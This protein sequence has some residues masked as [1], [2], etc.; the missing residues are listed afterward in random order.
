MDPGHLFRDDRNALGE[1]VVL[2][3][4]GP[5]LAGFEGADDGV[6]GASVVLGSVLV[7]G[8]VTAADMT[9][10]KAQPEVNPFVAGLEAF[11]ASVAARRNT[12]LSLGRAG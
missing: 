6:M 2:V 11:L 4:I 3:A 7:L 9:A 1:R 8:V 12:R 10:G 5:F